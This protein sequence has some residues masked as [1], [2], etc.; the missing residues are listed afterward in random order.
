MS[1]QLAVTPRCATLSR[2]AV[3]VA[4]A[5]SGCVPLSTPLPLRN[6]DR[7][8]GV[9]NFVYSEPI[10]YEGVQLVG[11]TV[12]PSSSGAQSYQAAQLSE[13]SLCGVGYNPNLRGRKIGSRAP[14][15]SLA[16]EE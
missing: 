13:A 7:A 14:S 15:C 1:G 12:V 10:A 4:I 11:A 2:P 16:L 8:V 5:G 3:G 6:S 9:G